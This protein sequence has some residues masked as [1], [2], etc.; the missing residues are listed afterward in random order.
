MRLTATVFS[1]FCFALLVHRSALA[2]DLP[3]L[4]GTP[5][6][7]VPAE[8]SGLTHELDLYTKEKPTGIKWPWMSPPVDIN[9][10]GHLDVMYYGHHGGG[11][12]VWFGKGDGT[13]RFDE[14]GYEDRWVFGARDPFW[15]D[16]NGDD[17][18]DAIGS[19]GYSIKGYLFVNDGT[20]HWS[21]SNIY[22]K[23]IGLDGAPMRP[24]LRL[25]GHL[26]DFDGDGRADGLWREGVAWSLQPQFAQWGDAPPDTLTLTMVWKAEETIG[27]PKDE[28]RKDSRGQPVPGYRTAYSVDLD[29][30]H[31]NELVVQ[32]QGAGGFS[33]DRVYARVLSRSS[34]S[35]GPDGW[36]DTTS[37]RGLPG[38]VGHWFYPDD[39]DSD[40]DLDLLDL[41]TG[42][43]YVNDAA[44]KFAQSRNP[45]YP[46]TGPKRW[47][48]DCEVNLIDL[49]NNG[50]RDLVMAA[51]HNS[52]RGVFLNFGDGRHREVKSLYA[53]NR[54]QR[55]FGDVDGD[56]DLDMLASTM[57]KRIALYR[58]DT[59][60]GGLR[61]RLVPKAA[62]EAHLGCKL[63][64]Y[65][66]GN[67]GDANSLIH[68]R[69]C[70]HGQQLTRSTL[71]LG[72][73]HIGLGEAKTVDI[74]VRFPSG[75]VR[76]VKNARAS[77]QNI[78]KEDAACATQ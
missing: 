72:D 17:M 67:M 22:Y 46:Q 76:E 3:P 9:G 66:A 57:H 8:Q 28:P 65:K 55:K 75:N 24:R 25:Y 11:A 71:L 4:E 73:L 47:D 19:E 61:L 2:A 59:T 45:I 74:R 31:R 18:L 32:F 37:G 12:A 41:Q 63:W 36:K 64:V 53:W 68:Y 51:D 35:D 60:D 38:A 50:R 69:Q 39:W 14:A 54:R 40:G 62:A 27:W 58:N 43:W 16:F 44:G 26:S 7:I 48:P 20:G 52:T 70:F 42:Q 10:D 1:A 29:G 30:D 33:S 77:S 78:L 49:D 13:F 21:K 6:V 5:L 56:G 15:W 23:T 34:D